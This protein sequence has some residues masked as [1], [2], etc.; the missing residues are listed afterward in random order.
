VDNSTK[1]MLKTKKEIKGIKQKYH[2]VIINYK[3]KKEGLGWEKE[4]WL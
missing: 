3:H 2:K 1:R 4:L